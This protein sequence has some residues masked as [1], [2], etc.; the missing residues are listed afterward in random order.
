MEINWK[1]LTRD[2]KVDLVSKMNA[3]EDGVYTIGNAIEQEHLE[4]Y[5]PFTQFETVDFYG[6]LR[7]VIIPDGAGCVPPTRDEQEKLHQRVRILAAPVIMPEDITITVDDNLA[8]LKDRWYLHQGLSGDGWTVKT[9]AGETIVQQLGDASI[10]VGRQIV[11]D[12][13]ALRKGF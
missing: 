1:N 3:D 8:R 10:A 9:G 4:H 6:S 11:S 5:I 7:L 12:H 2:G 13:N